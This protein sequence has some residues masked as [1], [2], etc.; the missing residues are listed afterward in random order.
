MRMLNGA[1]MAKTNS[2]VSVVCDAGPVIHLDELNLLDLLTDFQEI[3]LPDTVWEEIYQYRPSALNKVN[4]PLSR[5]SG[6]APSNEPLLTL[7]KIFSLDAGEIEALALMEQMPQ[8]MFLTDDAAARIVAIQMNFK[9]H[10]TIGILIRSIR[11]GQ[12]SPKEVLDILS[13]IPQKSTLYIRHSL[14]QEI[15]ASVKNEFNL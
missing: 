14:L 9:V 4:L 3:I 7:C 13:E 8:A 6:K 5:Q 1:C 12:M 2:K 15:L 10:G 11:K